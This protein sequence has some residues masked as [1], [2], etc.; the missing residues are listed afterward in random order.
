M[1]EAAK[2]R[3]RSGEVTREAIYPE[4]NTW[5]KKHALDLMTEGEMYIKYTYYNEVDIS[6][7]RCQ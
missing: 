7:H 1:L 5:K 4:T 2:T 3:H 6:H